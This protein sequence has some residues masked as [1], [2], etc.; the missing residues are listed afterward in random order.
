MSEP[1]T[2]A[3]RGSDIPAEAREGV[4]CALR[5]VY[6]WSYEP[7]IDEL[8]TL[9]ANALERQWIAGRDLD[10][11]AEVDPAWALAQ[12]E[13]PQQFPFFVLRAWQVIPLETRQ[14]IAVRMNA[15][16]LSQFLHGEQGALMVASQL[17]AA[18][19]HMDAK[20]YASTQTVD[21]ARH[22]E[23]FA[24][25]VR[26]LDHVYP[27][28]PVLRE[29][30]DVVLATDD[31]PK[32]AVGMQIVLE[33]LALAS[34]RNMRRVTREPLLSALLRRVSHDEARHTGYG[35]KYL[36]HVIPTLAEAHRRELED[37]AF[38]ATRMMMDQRSGGFG[39]QMLAIFTDEGIDVLEG[40]REMQQRRD[41]VREM[42]V[43]ARRD[44]GFDADPLRGFVL[45]TLAKIGLY[46][47]RVAPRYR[48]LVERNM[49]SG[50]EGTAFDGSFSLPEDL[51]GW[52]DQTS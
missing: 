18:V 10:W 46:H 32:K 35:Q 27:I 34:F 45:P 7:E 48:E 3:P 5:A 2:G 37:F 39:R 29:L 20:F 16:M 47:E 26:K 38:E 14:R 30:L 22:V 44:Q 24:A 12:L 52:V 40:F 4:E 11:D 50:F 9:Y 36:R 13:D 15:F 6:Q 51:E 31:W 1:A 21:E 28:D 42:L 8:R 19:P 41:E 23:A 17:V 33:G 25:Y 43:R 49:I